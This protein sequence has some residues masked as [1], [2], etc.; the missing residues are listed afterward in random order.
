MVVKVLHLAPPFSG[1]ITSAVTALVDLAAPDVEHVLVADAT[2]PERLGGATLVHCHHALRW[3]EARALADRLGVPAAKTLHILQARQ[4]HMRGLPP[5]AATRSQ[6]LQALALAQADALTIATHAAR[7]LLVADL[8]ALDPARVQVLPLPT[9]LP[10]RPRAADA[11]RGP[12]VAVTRFDALKGTDLLVA[13]VPLLVATVD[14][15]VV[16]AGGLPDNPRAERRWRDAFTS[17]LPPAHRDRLRFAGWL[18]PA[19]LAALLAT[20]R[21]F[22]TTSRLETCGLALMEAVAAGCPAVATDLPVHREV[23]GP[24][25]HYAAPSAAAFAAAVAEQL[26]TRAPD[27][28]VADPPLDDTRAAIVGAWLHFWR[29]TR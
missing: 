19:E 9:T 7:D 16:I 10:A 28:A 25:A 22:V 20:A 27:A 18:A 13:L 29:K 14:A 24:R 2:P 26:T 8:P 15:P 21:L 1:G 11:D 17:A 5:E 12:I 6:T 23:A 4:S 3:P